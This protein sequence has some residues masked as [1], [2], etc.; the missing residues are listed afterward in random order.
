MM[1]AFLLMFIFLFGILISSGTV[2]AE[3]VPAKLEDIPFA[4]SDQHTEKRCL[5]GRCQAV[6]Y[7]G[8]PVFAYDKIG[9]LRNQ[10]DVLSFSTTSDNRLNFSDDKGNYMMGEVIINYAGNNYSLS[11]ISTLRF[12]IGSSWGANI[13]SIDSFKSAR[14]FAIETSSIPADL[15]YIVIRWE[16]SSNLIDFN[17]IDLKLANF[18]VLQQGSETVIKDFQFATGNKSFLDPTAFIGNESAVPRTV[19]VTWLDTGTG[20]GNSKDATCRW[21]ATTQREGC[22]IWVNFTKVINNTGDTINNA[23]FYM[24]TFQYDIQLDVLSLT[25][26]SSNSH[27]TGFV[28]TCYGPDCTA[29]SWDAG[30]YSPTPNNNPC[31]YL[32]TDYSMNATCTPAGVSMP[33]VSPSITSAGTYS[34]NVTDIVISVKG[35][36]NAFLAYLNRSGN[37]GNTQMH[38]STSG[39]SALQY[40]RLYLDYTLAGPPPPP[41]VVIESPLTWY[42][43]SRTIFVNDSYRNLPVNITSLNVSGQGN[44]TQINTTDLKATR[45]IEALTFIENAVSL[46]SKY[47]QLSGGTLT[48]T[49]IS[50]LIKPSVDLT[51]DLGTET[52][53]FRNV[54]AQFINATGN[55]NA[56]RIYENGNRFPQPITCSGNNKIAV[57]NSDGTFT[58]QEDKI[59]L[60]I[61]TKLCDAKNCTVTD[62]QSGYNITVWAKGVYDGPAN[63]QQVRLFQNTTLAD[64]NQVDIQSTA[65]ADSFA[66]IHYM[67]TNSSNDVTYIV[68]STAGTLNNTKIMIQVAR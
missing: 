19:N 33:T 29:R 40:P 27:V 13:K 60:S 25:N 32:K 39:G 20:N 17:V 16:K 10:T 30:F 5:N 59:R 42:N 26:V 23:T 6:M 9:V 28:D 31:N 58:C 15:N 67:T 52:L 61:M 21:R 37:G 43:N 36:T 57:F 18:T 68:D 11:Q 50:Q 65:D 24:D 41:P 51:Y 34:W 48:G 56:S 66:L 22:M 54:W 14:K 12:L 63:P 62:I 38:S 2:S 49:L 55:L 1:K 46:A 8:P 4:P 44:F 53:R 35:Y 45:T 64:Q 47:L 7:G 3:S